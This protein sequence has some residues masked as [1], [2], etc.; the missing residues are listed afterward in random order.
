MNLTYMGDGRDR[1][2]YELIITSTGVEL[3]TD[4]SYHAT[5]PLI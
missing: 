1:R 5:Y 3:Q 2:M 4:H